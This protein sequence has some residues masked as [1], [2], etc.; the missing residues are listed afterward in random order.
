MLDFEKLSEN[1]RPDT[2]EWLY[3]AM[4]PKDPHFYD[5]KVEKWK[6]TTLSFRMSEVLYPNIQFT[7]KKDFL[8]RFKGDHCFLFD[9][10]KK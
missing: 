3:I 6:E 9:A 2:I 8:E 7:R 5:W 10:L 4:A 1:F